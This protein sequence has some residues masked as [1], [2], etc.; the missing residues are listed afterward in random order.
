MSSERTPF[1]SF[2]FL[3]KELKVSPATKKTVIKSTKKYNS[4]LKILSKTNGEFSIRKLKKLKKDF[5]ELPE[6]KQKRV[7]QDLWKLQTGDIVSL[8]DIKEHQGVYIPV[9]LI[10]V[11]QGQRCVYGMECRDKH[12]NIHKEQFK[13]H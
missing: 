8:S 1:E 7:I 4:F 12:K 13:L 3:S 2:S 6:E 5:I 9:W 11:L 10:E